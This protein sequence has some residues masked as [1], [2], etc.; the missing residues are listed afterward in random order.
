MREIEPDGASDIG[1]YRFA[2]RIASGTTADVFRALKRQAAGADRAVVIKRMLRSRASS[3]EARATFEHEAR[4]GLQIRHPNVVEV[5]DFDQHDDC[6]YL[7]LEYVFG[8]DLRK[9]AK[10]L[11]KEERRLP[12]ELAIWVATEI[13]AG[14]DAVH[15]ATDEL[16]RPL[17]VVHRDVSPS[18]VYVSVHGDVKLGDLGIARALG[19]R[20]NLP[21]STAAKGKIGYLAPEQVVGAPADARSDVFAAATIAAELLLG[22][23]L[24]GGGSELDVLLRIRDARCERLV[25][26]ARSWPARLGDV[27]LAALAKS[28]ARRTRGARELREA[29]LP[30]VAR[31]APELRN[32]LGREVVGAL[33]AAPDT[34]RTSLA[35]TIESSDGRAIAASARRTDPALSVDRRDTARPGVSSLYVVTTRA[36]QA[37]GP[38]TYARLVQ[39]LHTGEIERASQVAV[40][41]GRPRKLSDVPELAA[42]LPPSARISTVP[43]PSASSSKLGRTGESWDLGAIDFASVLLRLLEDTETGVLVCEHEGTRKEVFV[44][45]GEPTFVTSNRL[46]EMLGEHLVQ[47]G[48]IDRGELDVALAALPRYEGRLGDTLVALG[49]VEPLELF[50]HLARLERDKLLDVFGWRSGRLAL[51]RHAEKPTRGF[52][53]QLDAWDLVRA[54]LARELGRGTVTLAPREIVLREPRWQ[55]GS[56]SL[57]ERLAVLLDRLAVPHAASELGQTEAEKADV[58]LLVA[59][60]AAR[61][62]Q[63]PSRSA[64]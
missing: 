3:P 23:P 40:D 1:P 50:G 26:A 32:A 58:L 48:V 62:G 5:L 31:A 37:L 21:R 18:N 59:L 39:A 60:G 9:L 10:W 2:T 4:L 64:P 53:L 28:P 35:Q 49:L 25:Q 57:P 47:A 46:G 20:S 34:D 43:P 19:E 12:P 13:L 54:G 15:S 22:G 27:L 29:L 56:A 8:V 24:F 38:W 44:V 63:P 33:D 41:G 42:H 45:Q 6:P 61:R 14:L 51:Y 17:H 55:P 36:G 11:A 52:P 16:G 7:V 30:Y